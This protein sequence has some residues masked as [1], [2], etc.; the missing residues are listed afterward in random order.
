[1]NIT[2][3]TASMGFGHNSV[4]FALKDAMEKSDPRNHIVVYDILEDSRLSQLIKDLYLGVIAKTPYLYSKAYHWSQNYHNTDSLHN[5]LNLMFF[6][7]LATI[8]NRYGTDGFIF[9]HPFPAMGYDPSLNVPSWTVITDYGFHPIWYNPKVSGY[10]TANEEIKIDLK[11]KHYPSDRVFVTGIP[12]KG[13]F[14]E[15][16]LKKDP[17]R[18]NQGEE[19]QLMIMGGGLGIGP[20]YEIIDIVKDLKLPVNTY[21]LTGNNT[22]LYTRLKSNIE[23]EGLDNFKVLSF[24]KEIP[25]LMKESTIL[26]TKAG[27]V[28]LAEAALSGIPTIIYKPIPGH[29]E[30][31]AR[32]VCKHGWALWP[33][34]S[35]ELVETI[36][37]L[38]NSESI[39]ES[40]KNNAL[41][42]SMPNAATEVSSRIV[43]EISMPMRR[44]V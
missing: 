8:K 2:I 18:V 20:T 11:K 27:A 35:F 19:K 3:V 17:W 37:N 33:K 22:D 13:S 34:N 7:S 16:A 41:K 24:T 6:K 44:T 39:L 4:A 43:N 32:N 31:N 9:T 30:D 40:M 29:E 10:F 12:T 15:A 14:T 26:I 25:K 5:Y 1:M 28:T 38:L 36:K 42:F 23:T 21:I